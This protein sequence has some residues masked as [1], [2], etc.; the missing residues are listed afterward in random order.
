[1]SRLG[2]LIFEKASSITAG[3]LMFFVHFAILLYA[4]FFFFLDG[5]RILERMLYYMPLNRHDEKRLLD[6]FRSMARATIKG[7]VVI[8]AVQGTLAGL[9]FWAAGIGS[10]LFWGTVM[11][12]LSVVPNIGSA[13]VWL[14]AGVILLI[15]GKTAAGALLLIWCAVVVGSADN[16]LRPI[17]IGKDTRVHELLVLISTL[18]G[19]SMMGLGGF[20]L[21]PVLALLFLTVW[22]IYGR[23]F[24]DVLPSTG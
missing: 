4:M 24:K 15:K 17:L 14:P 3:T 8:G 12:V 13:L 19:L 5:P 21:G 23:A 2:K 10:A 7:I 16:V 20:V 18:G 11:A 1:V 6:G 22:D 9:G